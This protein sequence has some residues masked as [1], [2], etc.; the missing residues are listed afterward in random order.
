MFRQSWFWRLL[1]LNRK[2]IKGRVFAVQ[3][4]FIIRVDTAGPLWLC[5]PG[6]TAIVQ[7]GLLYMKRCSATNVLSPPFLFTHRHTITHTHILTTGCAVRPGFLKHTHGWALLLPPPASLLQQTWCWPWD[8]GPVFLHMWGNAV[9]PAEGLLKLSQSHVFT[10]ATDLSCAKK[11]SPIPLARLPQVYIFP[12]KTCSSYLSFP[13]VV[14][15]SLMRCRSCRRTGMVS[16]VSADCVS[17]AR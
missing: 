12:Y 11:R 7:P 16:R 5:S 13:I 3:G 1:E 2:I 4:A 15:W 6:M 8:C 10:L 14:P 9:P 17:E